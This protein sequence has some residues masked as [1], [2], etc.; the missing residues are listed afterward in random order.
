MPG[1]YVIRAAQ[2][3]LNRQYEPMSFIQE[4]IDLLAGNGYNTLMLYIA[5]R[6]TIHSHPWQV[7][8]G[9]YTQ[10]EIRAIVSYAQEK[11]L[12][13]IPTTDLTFVNS[14]TRFPE[15]GE[16]M[17][18]GTRF[19]G[20]R[21]GNFCTSNPKTYDFIE[22]Y[23][24]ELAE[25]VP[26]EY[27]HI[28]GDEAWDLGFCEHCTKDGFDFDKECR[29][30]RDFI[31]KVHSIVAGKLRRRMI[32]WDDMFEYYPAVLPEMP[33]DIIMA[34]WL[35]D[36]DVTVTRGHFGNRRREYR[37]AQYEQLGFDYLIAAATR[38]SANGRTFTEYAANGS[39]LLGGIMTTWCVHLRYMYKAFPTIASI[40][41]LWAKGGDEARHYQEA[42]ADL[43]GVDNALLCAAFRAFSEGIMMRLSNFNGAWLCTMPFEGM[44]F[45][46]DSNHELMLAVL[47]EH[48]ALVTTEVGRKVTT[49]IIRSLELECAIFG[50]K[51]AFR[52][53]IAT[54]AREGGFANA[55]E[56]VKRTGDAYADL[57]KQWRPGIGPNHIA[58]WLGKFLKDAEEL[59]ERFRSGNCLRIL[60]ALPN[61]F[62]AEQATV[63]VFEKGGETVLAQGCFKGTGTFYERFFPLAP[64]Q[65]P[66]AVKIAVKGYGGQGVAHVA[67]RLDG[68]NVPPSKVIAEGQVC[69]EAHILDDDC[70]FAFLG[71]QD[72]LKPWQNRALAEEV[73]SI[74]VFFQESSQ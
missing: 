60:F 17:E 13:V 63:S 68:Q 48:E 32:M 29:L 4:Y 1:N 65:R 59:A 36:E 21:R 14:L 33:R 37:L 11:G 72:A 57:W 45:A 66:D 43:L 69:N 10:D 26:S 62:G 53:L 16:L 9:S 2:I 52:R 73:S 28:G 51:L 74:T 34:D 47:K 46:A 55:M 24:T 54:P 61:P 30:Y 3:D 5:W 44:H 23:L 71:D 22:N 6:V 38:T 7:P 35:Y 41:R 67:L 20:S 64:T 42:I 40:G 8:G 25:L 39:H 19:W 12:Q 15:L 50:L 27:F 70:K 58:G 49:E 56:R 18:T 31:L